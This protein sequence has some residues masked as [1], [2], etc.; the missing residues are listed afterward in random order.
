MLIPKVNRISATIPVFTPQK[1]VAATPVSCSVDMTPSSQLVG[2]R[3]VP[4]PSGFRSPR[5]W[6]GR[7]RTPGHAW[8]AHRSV[9]R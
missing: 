8:H 5:P 9:V 7:P 4:L 2:S 6:S 3:T 1:V